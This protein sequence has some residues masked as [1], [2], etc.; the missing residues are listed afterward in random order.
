MRLLADSGHYDEA[1]ALAGRIPLDLTLQS[2]L[3]LQ[4]EVDAICGRF[5]EAASHLRDLQQ[6]MSARG[7]DGVALE[8]G[9][10]V[11]TL[12]L[13]AGDA[14]ALSRIDGELVEHPLKSIDVYSRPYLA[15]A[16]LYAAA[17]RP[18]RA[19]IL[20]RDYE[21]EYPTRLRGPDRW[22][23]LRARASIERA[24]GKTQQAI[25]DLQEA[26]H[27]AAIRLGLFDE[28]E[29]RAGDEPELARLY[30]QL[31]ARDSAIAVYERYLTIRSLDRV[32]VDAIE[33]APT[34]SRLAALYEERGDRVTA[35]RYYRQFAALW[36][37]GDLVAR[38][39]ASIAERRAS[40]LAPSAA[41]H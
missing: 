18:A 39:R 41:S 26:Q 21:R 9:V 12:R 2:G 38:R 13:A 30:E 24:E 25:A 8:L 35:A 33:L 1:H 19:G 5:D 3:R 14:S 36:H 23:L 10:A 28:A 15:L 29:I 6:I 20:L 32:R 17:N 22:L 7:E 27:V 34:L 37:A 11:A 31:G 4:A 40:V 16:R